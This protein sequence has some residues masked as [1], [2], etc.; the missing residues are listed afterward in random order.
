MA[1]GRIVE[2]GTSAELRSGQGRF[3]AL[4]QAWIDSLV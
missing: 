1:D 3:A 2:D 4:N